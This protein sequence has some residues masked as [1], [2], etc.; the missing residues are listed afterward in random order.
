MSNEEQKKVLENNF[1]KFAYFV[2]NDD[3]S[4]YNVA[5]D[6]SNESKVKDTLAALNNQKLS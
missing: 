5:Y 2:N 3:K 6:K 1:I 4:L